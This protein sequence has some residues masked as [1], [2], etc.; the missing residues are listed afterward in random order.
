MAQR[1]LDTLV[2]ERGL[3][4]SRSAAATSIRAGQVRIGKGGER[5][6]KPGRMVPEE[7]RIEID[8]GR[9]YVSRGGLKL[10]AALDRFGID[11]AGLPCLDVGASTGGFTDCLLQ[12]GAEHVVALDVGR[13]QL[14]WGL[15]NDERVTVIEGRNARELSPGELPFAPQLV[16][17]DVSFIAVAKLLEPI[18]AVAADDGL[19]LAMVKPQFELGRGRV[20]RGGVVRDPALRAEA[21]LEVAEAAAGLGLRCGGVAAAGVPG[22]KGNVEIFLLLGRGVEPLADLRE[23][24]LAEAEGPGPRLA[25]AGA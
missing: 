12:R 22:P 13:G 19:I 21:V 5:P 10:E 23:R 15:R 18:L 3:A 20:G 11:V 2:A 16:T 6:T 24:A 7:I 8:G 14:D 17:I 4:P 25:E 9:P 1:R